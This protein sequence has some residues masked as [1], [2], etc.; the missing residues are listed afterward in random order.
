MPRPAKVHDNSDVMMYMQQ[1]LTYDDLPD[2]VDDCIRGS[3]GQ[4]PATSADK[5]SKVQLMN[6]L[7]VMDVISVQKLLDVSTPRRIALGKKSYTVRYAQYICRALTTAS[8]AIMHHADRYA[9]NLYSE[10]V[11]DD[12]D[13]SHQIA[14]DKVDI[15]RALVAAAKWDELASIMKLISEDKL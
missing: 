1:F 6:Y 2:W 7:Q 15:I 10:V 12:Y 13:K 4:L 14:S 5:I 3:V 8:Q 9:V 11:E